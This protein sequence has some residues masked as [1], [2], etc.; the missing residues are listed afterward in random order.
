MATRPNIFVN[1]VHLVLNGVT[2]DAGDRNG[3]ASIIVPVHV[4]DL[5]TAFTLDAREVAAALGIAGLVC[6]GR[7]LTEIEC[8][9]FIVN[10]HF[11]GLNGEVAF[12]QA[13][14]LATFSFD[15]EMGDAPISTH[16][17]FDALTAQYG[18][19]EEN[20]RFPRDAPGKTGS[21]T[22]LSKGKTSKKATSP[23]FG[24][25]SWLKVGATF[26]RTYAL[27]TPNA[28]IYEGIG[29]LVSY[30][31]GA[32]KLGLPRFK[33]R[34]WLKLA[35]QVDTSAGSAVR[36][37]ERYRLTGQDPDVAKQIYGAGQLDE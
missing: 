19:D 6:T 22:G 28:S 31:P 11:E 32:E 21:T 23:V 9:E 36:V 10:F 27:T 5:P 34:V 13:E 2:G 26:S 30:P 37:T 15:G 29:T 3:V 16:P 25:E 24:Q 8:G 17:N 33:R 14:Q 35:P 20:E 12:E 4:P 18:W 7:P 1:G